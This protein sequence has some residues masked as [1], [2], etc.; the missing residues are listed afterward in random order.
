M[1][2]PMLLY[3]NALFNKKEWVSGRGRR[4][5]ISV[6]KL[7]KENVFQPLRYFLPFIR[8]YLCYFRISEFLSWISAKETQLMGIKS[9]AIS[10]TNHGDVERTVEVG[11]APFLLL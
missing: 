7:E 8:K 9:E 3:R 5:H 4:K 11:P 2:L 10:A 1:V 6:N